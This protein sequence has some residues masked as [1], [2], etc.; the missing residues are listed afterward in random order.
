MNKKIIHIGIIHILLLSSIT[1]LSVTGLR[2]ENENINNL[3]ECFSILMIEDKDFI[4]SFSEK[5]SQLIVE[6]DELNIIREKPLATGGSTFYVDD[7]NTGGPWDGSV[8]NP[9][10]KIQSGIN[11][12]GVGDTVY[13]FSGTYYE[14]LG[15]H[16]PINLIG[17]DKESTIIDGSGNIIIRDYFSSDITIK[18]FSLINANTESAVWDH[19]IDF[20]GDVH[21]ICISDC[22]FENNGDA[23]KFQKN[24][25]NVLISDCEI[26][27]HPESS[28][29]F[30]GYAENITI[31]NCIVENNG[32]VISDMMIHNGGIYFCYGENNIVISNCL[33]KNNIGFGI[34]TFESSKFGDCSGLIINY[35]YIEGNTWGG[36]HVR[37]SYQNSEIRG[38]ELIDNAWT[39]NYGTL[40]L[41]NV[42][43]LTITNNNITSYE[44]CGLRLE[45]SSNNN[46]YHN[47]FISNSQ[48]AV[49]DAESGENHWDD[50]EQGNYWGDYEGVDENPE[51][52]IG[53]TPYEISTN[54]QDNYPWMKPNGEG[55]KAKNKNKQ[56]YSSYNFLLKKFIQQR[57]IV[58]KI[59]QRFLKL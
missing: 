3:S 45:K 55:V 29:I 19:A 26:K 34:D 32:E 58:F 53:D 31:D 23:I 54:N 41:V 10:N 52:G 40:Y 2:I 57:L 28:I 24:C 20:Q 35:N 44:K 49:C 43:G 17:E 33:I 8:E 14:N 59:L 27:N 15:V 42:D 9:F 38:N 39:L 48:N 1:S 22:I 13:V 12:A 56:I 51:D 18:G 25:S 7:D 50:G 4:V 47:N 5:E 36:I 37:G 16:Y 21:D 46:I 6:Y 11:K 30:F